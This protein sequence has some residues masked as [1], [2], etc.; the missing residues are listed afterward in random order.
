MCQYTVKDK[1]I[2]YKNIDLKTIQEYISKSY[3]RP[4][5]RDY[6]SELTI[7][8]DD[9]LANFT[10]SND[11]FDRTLDYQKIEMCVLSYFRHTTNQKLS[12]HLLRSS[13]LTWLSNHKA[14]TDKDIYYYLYQ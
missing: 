8:L 10:S 1:N 3:E 12:K 2:I 5:K 6:M 9:N 7:M 4:D 13:T 11:I 14:V